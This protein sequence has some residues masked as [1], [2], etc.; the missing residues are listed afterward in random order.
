MR[1]FLLFILA[2]S[3]VLTN[4]QNNFIWT[5]LS[6]MLEPVSNNAVTE[7][8]SGDTLFVYSFCGISSGLAPADIHL[9]SWR[10]N[11]LS[12]EWQMLEDVDDTQGKIAAGASTVNNIIYLMG[13][14]KVNS[15]FS[16][17][18]SEKVHRFDCENNA[19]LSEGTPMPVPVDDHVQTVWRDSLIFVVTGWSDNTNV[20][21]VQIYNPYLDTWQAGTGTPNNNDFKAFGT[22]GTIIGDTIYY[23]GGTQINANSFTANRKFRK[24]VINPENPTEIAWELLPEVPGE[25]G[26][27]T[28]AMNYQNEAIWIGGAPAAYNFDGMAYSNGQGVEPLETIRLYRSDTQSWETY[29]ASDNPVMDLRGIAKVADNAWIIAGGMEPNQLVS[30]KTYLV[31]RGDAVSIRDIDEI[32]YA[33]KQDGASFVIDFKK[34]MKGHYHIHTLT[35][36]LMAQYSINGTNVTFDLSPF[37]SGMYVVSFVSEN[38]KVLNIKVFKP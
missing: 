19:W 6:P 24:G 29:D 9:K 31:T 35:G 28:A 2:I 8:Y 34:E 23:F 12:D 26:Y 33:L 32:D 27:R 37:S 30:P 38:E 10:Y 4:A 36:Q 18:T 25:N 1:K 22:S 14:Y 21:N 7:G 20:N 11:T 13:G 3:P 17:I 15:N 16:E 5:E